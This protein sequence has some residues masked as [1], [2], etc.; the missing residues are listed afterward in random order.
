MGGYVIVSTFDAGP[1]L[2]F[3]Q[4]QEELYERQGFFSSSQGIVE[5]H[6][7]YG[8]CYLSEQYIRTA[9]LQFFDIVE[10]IPKGLDNQ[11][12]VVLRK[13]RI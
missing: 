5:L 11:N 6:E 4:S 1:S 8:T 7:Y 13:S 12:V 10:Y 9:W 2:R 3:T